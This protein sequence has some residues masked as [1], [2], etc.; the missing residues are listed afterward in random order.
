MIISSLACLV[1]AAAFGDNIPFSA[2]RLRKPHT[3]NVAV[4]KGTLEQFAKHRAG[5]DEVWF[6]TGICFPKMD[7][8]RA[9]AKRLAAAAE[10]LRKIGILPS[11]QIQSTIGHGD[12]FVRYADNS[13][14]T[15]HGYV[16]ANGATAKACNCFRA[17]AFVAYMKEMAS[18]YAAA[19][20]PYSMWIDDDIRVVHHGGPG[21]GC[22]CEYCL[23]K[24]AEKEGQKR[25]RQ[26]LVE[27]MKKDAELEA[28]WRAFAF[29]GEAELVRAIAEAVHAA[30][31]TTRMCQQQPGMCYPEH[32]MLYE[33]SYVATGLPVGMR[34]GAGS[35]F[36]YDPRDQILKAYQLALQIDIIGPASYIDRICPEIESCP[37][38][39]ACRSGRGVL[40]EALEALS[41]GMNSISA[42][43]MDAG[44]ETPEWYGD[45][46]LSSLARNSAMLKRYVSVNKGAVRSGYGVSGVPAL[47]LRSG[48]LPLK[49]LLE[50]A[51]SA[52]ARIV[53]AKVAQ[54]AISKGKDA[55]ARLLSEDLLIDG[56]AAANLF[57]AG[58]GEAIGIAGCERLEGHLRE[59]FMD[60]PVN[61][62]FKA[63]ETPIAG[64][65]FF[66]APAA[67]AKAISGY[68]SDANP[69]LWREAA[70]VM[71]E[72]K[73]G[74][75]RVVFGHD[76][77]TTALYV[78]SGDRVLQLHRLADWAS[79]GK[80]PVLL[81]TPT[82]SFV[83]PRVR[84]DGT[85]ASV[86]FVNASIGQTR[87]IRMRLRGVASRKAVWSAL[88][89]ADVVLDVVRD[90]ADAIV[91]LPSVS[92]WTGGYLV[93]E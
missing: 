30:A 25:S 32:K 3:D 16:A 24:F 12:D 10:D 69:G 89:A 85:L 33:A 35:Y 54:S 36:D 45:E 20:R 75:R 53:T 86:V 7:E 50:D 15:W 56:S 67:G 90:G 29:E 43:V 52:L 59:R 84:A 28:R 73:V 13:G 47:E 2:I 88:D 40:L 6:S 60:E 14:M 66:L 92:A 63:R 19:M 4:W 58:Y 48:S 79:H 18:I 64:N 1:A 51:H 80:S 26:Q 83:Q 49:P 65:A 44:F 82:R 31:P 38:S 70:T 39:F 23:G 11:L 76:A 22:H 57:D 41:Q 91:V 87:P 93:F 27:E 55:V 68:Y 8:H 77:F 34:P 78:A 71:F 81:E 46:I 62:G 5:V 17:P 74:R 21:W 9:S 61:K 37:R 72:D 42:L